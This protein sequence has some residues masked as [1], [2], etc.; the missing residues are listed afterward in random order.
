MKLPKFTAP[1]VDLKTGYISREWYQ[2]L[3]EIDN[4]PSVGGGSIED[5][6]KG[7][8]TVASGVWTIDN[9]AVTLAKQANVSSGTVFYRKTAGSGSPEVQTLATLKSD[10]GLTGTNS[11]DQDISGKEDKSN[12][13]TSLS[14]SS[15]DA[16]YPSAKAVYD[17]IEELRP[18]SYFATSM[19]VNTGTLDAG[20]VGDLSATGGTDVT[21]SEGTGADPLRVTFAFSGVARLT[22]FSFYGYYAGGSGHTLAAEIYNT[23]TTNWDQIGT[24]GS[25]SSKKWYAFPV[26]DVASYLSAGAVSVRLRHV[27]TGN[28]THDLY[29]DY[30]DLHYGG[31][32]GSSTVEAA[33]VVYTPSGSISATN[34]ASAINELDT[35]KAASTHTHAPADV[36]GTAVITS[37]ARLS[38]ARNAADV[39]TWAKAATKPTYTYTEVGAEQSGAVATHAALSTGVHGSG[40]NSLIYSNDSRLT[41]ARTPTAH[42]QAES[43]ITFTDIT[44]GNVSTSSHGFFPKLP[45][46]TGKYFRD[47]GTWQA[48]AGG[49]DVVGDDTSTT[50]QNIV[51]YSGVGGKNITELTG[52]QGDVLYHNG[53][54]WAKLGS[55]TSGY[56]L[57]T[58]GASANPKWWPC[59]LYNASTSNQGAGFATDTYITGSSILIHPGALKVGSMYSVVIRVSKTAA[60]TATPIVNIRFGTNGT[61]ADTSRGTLTWTAGTAAADD[62]IIQIWMTV[63]ASGTSGTI[64]TVGRITHKLSVTGLTGTAAVSETE[65]ADS[66]TFDQTVANSYIGL[67]LNAGGSA[68][69]TVH[70]VQAKL[71]NLA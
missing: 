66:G 51:A 18:V 55:G 56:F 17:D 2:H 60:G 23:V 68:A 19:T 13:V 15:T 40:A 65:V 21:I 67:S 8:I 42:S 4:T 24:V 5:G 54:N 50:A 30:L 12:K 6:D 57:M 53:T 33:S 48:I 10:L 69:W 41:D 71:E 46:S 35:E 34:V 43:T 38:D 49:G 36:T 20:V 47:D 58:M 27:Q 3:A 32:S 25:E 59:T 70:L 44:T 11:G 9:G 22:S 7:D 45:T 52:A 31:T 16:Q 28:A 63:T 61:T 62:G 64:R 29:V 1:L 26:Y 39:Y 14:G 37:D